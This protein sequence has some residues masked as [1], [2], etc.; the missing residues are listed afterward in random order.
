MDCMEQHECYPCI[1]SDAE[2]LPLCLGPAMMHPELKCKN[3]KSD[4]WAFRPI[5]KC[6]HFMKPT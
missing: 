1:W 5:S 3:E 4:K 2:E 6:N